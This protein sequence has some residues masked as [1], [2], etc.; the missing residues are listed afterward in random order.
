MLCKRPHFF[1][2]AVLLSVWPATALSQ[3]KAQLPYSM[4]SSYQELFKSLQHLDLISPSI[5]ILSTDPQVAPTD[6]LFKIKLAD[7][8]QNF[9]PDEN[10]VIEFPDQPDWQNLNLISNQPKGT[11]QLVIGFKARQLSS[12]TTTYQQLMGLVPQF[13]EAMA[14]LATMQGQPAPELKGLTIQLPEEPGGT[15]SILSKK[16]ETTLKASSAGMV[17]MKY[18]QALWDENPAVEFSKVPVGIIPLQ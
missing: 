5:I 4:V 13:K 3:E 1:L 18:K 8:W 14:A 9:S 11:L 10:G 7:D 15:V 16:R 12:T 6:I 2:L 17:I